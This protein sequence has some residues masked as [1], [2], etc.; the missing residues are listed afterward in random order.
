M[1]FLLHWALVLS[2][3][4]MAC[5]LETENFLGCCENHDGWDLLKHFIYLYRKSIWISVLYCISLKQGQEVLIVM[6]LI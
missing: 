5:M 3:T 1:S 6:S 2:E 4:I